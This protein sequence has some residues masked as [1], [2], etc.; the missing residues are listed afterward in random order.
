MTRSPRTDGKFRRIYDEHFLAIH[1]YRLRRLPMI[2]VNV[3]VAKVFLVL[4]RRVDHAPEGTDAPLWL[5]GVALSV[6]RNTHRSVGRRTRLNGTLGPLQRTIGPNPEM[7]IVRRS[8]DTEVL[9]SL[10]ELRPADQE[11]VR[12]SFWEDLTN[13]EIAVVVGAVP[14]PMPSSRD[15][16][17]DQQPPRMCQGC[18]PE[19]RR[20]RQW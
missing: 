12:L 8:T 17:P 1:R 7:L 10:A 4:W 9:G 2:E 5:Y 19:L 15:R 16:R 13:T 14:C 18:E 11:I 6:V 20:G 3:A